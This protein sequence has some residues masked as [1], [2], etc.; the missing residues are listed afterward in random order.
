MIYFRRVSLAAARHVMRM[1]NNLEPSCVNL[2][3]LGRIPEESRPLG[4]PQSNPLLKRVRE[5]LRQTSF[6]YSMTVA[7]SDSHPTLHVVSHDGTG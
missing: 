4:I 6:F 2:D 1:R 7:Y 5:R 3:A